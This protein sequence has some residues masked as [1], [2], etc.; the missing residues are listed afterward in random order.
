M[1]LVA[2]ILFRVFKIHHK[3]IRSHCATFVMINKNERIFAERQTKG[4]KKKRL[5][6][7]QR[8][9]RVRSS[10]VQFCN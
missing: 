2:F 3:K 5:I 4:K 7:I 10:S 8:K 6:L 1:F 9:T